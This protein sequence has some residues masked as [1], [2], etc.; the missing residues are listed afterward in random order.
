MQKTTFGYLNASQFLVTLND[1]IF[2]LLVAYKLIDILGEKR[3][4]EILAI[5]AV[6]FVIPFI[7][8]SMPA[9]QLA[10]RI[11]KQKLI[12]WT[13]WGEI[14]FM[15]LG[16]ISI[17]SNNVPLTY[18]A[19]FLVGLQA[20]VFNPAKYAIIPELEPPE[21]ITSV[22][23][24]MTFFTYLSIILGTFLT[25]FICD[26]SGNNFTLVAVIC[27][28]FAVISLFTG[29]K[30]RKTPIQNPKRAVN[31]YFFV[32]V[33]RA[34]KT[35]LQ[36][37]RLVMAILAS[38]YFLFTAGYTQLNLIPFGVQ[39]LGITDI[40]TGYVYLA[41]ALGLGIGSLFVSIFS[42]RG[43]ELGLSIWGALGTALSYLFLYIFQTHL[44]I[45]CFI[46]F[47]IGMHGALYVVPLDAY[48]QYA[49]PDRDRGTYVA[50][51]SFLS[52]VAVLIAALFLYVTG[53]IFHMRAADGYLIVAYLTF[54]VFLY[55]VFAIG[56]YISRLVAVV[57]ARSFY[58]IHTLDIPAEKFLVCEKRELYKIF[59]LVLTFPEI[60]FIEAVEKKPSRWKKAGAFFFNTVL[61][62][63]G[64]PLNLN[65]ERGSYCLFVE[66]MEEAEEWI[67]KVKPLISSEA[68]V[69]NIELHEKPEYSFFHVFKMLGKELTI[70]F[71]KR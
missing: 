43:V 39:S 60:T 18:F 21:R 70:T 26:I 28:V 62:E 66:R 12:V 58:T 36:Y 48:I 54:G 47:S 15:V 16:L 9:G 53:N 2:R 55:L 56:E 64:N 37:P 42:S 71:V 63:K 49:S 23:G 68:A 34:L 67:E 45:A 27:I 59:S 20:A 6:L 50:S 69:V 11:S 33:F 41:A 14:L 38:S 19:L 3:N 4:N 46:F 57:Y 1:S 30:I 7:L 31:P 29:W 52:F 35:G 51:G 61:V 8:F 44:V 65:K 24:F 5:S 40:E 25:S 17:M 13:L 22:N 32:D 10:D